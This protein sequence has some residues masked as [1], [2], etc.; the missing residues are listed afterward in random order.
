MTRLEQIDFES[1]EKFNTAI[2]KVLAGEEVFRTYTD[3][4]GNEQK[5]KIISN[6]RLYL[7][8]NMSLNIRKADN[9]KVYV[10]VDYF[11]VEDRIHMASSKKEESL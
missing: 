7:G 9:G 2:T 5:K 11:S 6:H 10:S 8:N 4:D 3:K 1:T